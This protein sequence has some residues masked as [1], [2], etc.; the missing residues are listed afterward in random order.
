MWELDGPRTAKGCAVFCASGNDLKNRV[1]FPARDPNADCRWSIDGWRQLAPIT[2]TSDQKSQ[3]SPHRAEVSK[4]YS[5]PMF[6]F[7]NRG[8]NI[9]KAAR[10]GADGLHTNRLW[11]NLVC[12]S[13]GSGCCRIGSFNSSKAQSFGTAGHPHAIRRQ[14]WYRI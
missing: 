11:R 3:W 12:Y 5:Q 7:D 13:A 8:F 2:R 1:G 10:G 14:N 6:R 4:G 9:G